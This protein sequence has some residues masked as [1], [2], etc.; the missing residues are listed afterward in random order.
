M[1]METDM[2]ENGGRA[3]SMV[4]G[5]IPFLTVSD[6]M[7]NLMPISAMD[8]ENTIGQTVTFIMGIGKMTDVT[9]KV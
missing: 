4:M 3:K 9:V 7:G 8:G 6:M 1:P 2:K 5:Y